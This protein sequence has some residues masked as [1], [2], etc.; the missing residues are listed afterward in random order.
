MT[1]QE[2]INLAVNNLLLVAILSTIFF[3]GDSI[4]NWVVRVSKR[5]GKTK[6]TGFLVA[7]LMIVV[8]SILPVVLQGFLHKLLTFW[9]VIVVIIL[10]IVASYMKYTRRF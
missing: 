7:L 8:L 9:G 3:F 6:F 4:Y 2:L 1:I 5:I 10:I